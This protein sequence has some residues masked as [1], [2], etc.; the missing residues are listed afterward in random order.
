MDLTGLPPDPSHLVPGSFFLRKI[1][2]PMG[3]FI[4][5]GQSLLRGGSNYT[6]AG[7]IL[8]SGL[9]IEAEPGGAKIRQVEGLWDHEPVLIS[10][11]P[12]RRWA[13][14]TRFPALLGAAEEATVSKRLEIVGKARLLEG[15]PYSFLDYLAMAAVEFDWPGARWLRDRVEDSQHLICSA[16]VDRVYS[17]CGV[18]LFDDRPYRWDPSKSRVPG[19]V[20]PWD[21][22][23]FV[24]TYQH[25]LLRTIQSRNAQ[26]DS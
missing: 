7:I 17:W 10:D 23:Q 11:A 14:T 3:R 2:G 24:L 15:T 21:L 9:M 22:E 12:V 16:L 18:H 5:M 20:T 26:E 13:Q 19:D 6:H 1:D 8:D 4:A 25:D